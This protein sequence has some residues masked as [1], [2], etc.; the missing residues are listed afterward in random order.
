MRDVLFSSKKMKS[1]QRVAKIALA[2]GLLIL[3]GCE[4]DTENTDCEKPAVISC[5]SADAKKLFSVNLCTSKVTEVKTCSGTDVCVDADGPGGEAATCGEATNCVGTVQR[6][7]NPDDLKNIYLADSCGGF[8]RS[9]TKCSFDK[10]CEDEDG[11]GP[12]GATCVEGEATCGKTLKRVCDPENPR[13][14]FWADSCGGTHSPVTECTFYGFVCVDEDGPGGT[15]AKCEV[16][17]PVCNPTNDLVC[18]ASELSGLFAID[19]CGN[20]L[21]KMSDCNDD[22]RCDDPDGV[23]GQPATCIAFVEE[24]RK[25]TK[26]VCDVDDPDNVLWAD[27]CGG[28][29]SVAEECVFTSQVCVDKDGPG[30]AQADC[31]NPDLGCERDEP[32][33]G[34][35]RNVWGSSKLKGESLILATNDCRNRTGVVTETC[36]Y[37][38]FC[39]TKVTGA[40]ACVSSMTDTASPYF[41]LGCTFPDF[42]KSPTDLPADCRCRRAYTRTV[43]AG[44]PNCWAADTMWN[45]NNRQGQGPSVFTMN[46][47]IFGGV[48]STAHNEFFVSV[49][50]TDSNH[51]HAGLI[52]AYNYDTG[53]RRV[54]SGK[55]PDPSGPGGYTEY[56]SGHRTNR[57]VGQTILEDMTFPHIK[58]IEL[59][60]DG[61]LYAFGT[62]TLANTEITKVDPIT[63][64]RTLVWKVQAEGNVVSPFGQ[65]FSARNKSAIPGG[66]APIQF[67]TR[68]YAMDATT[69]KHYIGF[70]NPNDGVGIMEISADGLACR[71]VTR[72]A[73]NE[74]RIGD[75]YTPQ[76][77]PIHGMMARAGNVYLVYEFKDALVEVEI[78]T[79]KRT[80]I[81]IAEGN[82]L[83][84]GDPGMAQ[85]NIFWDDT[86]NYIWTMGSP[87]AYYGIVVD[88][89]TGNRQNPYRAD[90]AGLPLLVGA[91]P[92]ERPIL[93]SIN[94]ANTIGFGA[95]AL[96]PNDNN[97]VL[98]IGVY[99]EMHELELSTGNCW[100]KSL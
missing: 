46:T 30:G 4:E 34:Q 65:C 83:G 3:S 2:I 94:N 57:I 42:I 56:G 9:V 86:R 49:G 74:P 93:C 77:G 92:F 7:C 15:D 20:K 28:I 68:A 87:A 84:T 72:H 85:N 95:A 44:V 62:D 96:H 23:G 60:S 35:C 97:R 63:G 25:S 50:Y 11:A 16:P 5:G 47:F 71:V 67:A 59:G 64:A 12:K 82:A 27:S 43:G 24:C 31:K 13:T 91:Y 52:M 78:A 98:V 48:I 76:Y 70:R 40:P 73:G 10:V 21:D 75:G 29:H 14:V 80:A 88:P 89:V 55:H 8:D 45:S 41:E 61:M 22:Q 79:G 6:V 17:E 38:E 33:P 19:S 53:D 81:S 32:G 54:V 36:K 99:G 37:G 51:S 58:D 90:P 66:K 39:S 69:L 1:A 26:R 18:K 100:I